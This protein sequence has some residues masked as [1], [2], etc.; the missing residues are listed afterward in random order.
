MSYCGSGL[1][2]RLDYVMYMSR[3]SDGRKWD[4]NVVIRVIVRYNSVE[5]SVY[6]MF[7]NGFLINVSLF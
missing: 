7:L 2:R 5:I 3:A 6:S 4:V 1:I